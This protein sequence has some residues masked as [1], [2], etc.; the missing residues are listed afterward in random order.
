[1]DLG[2][3]ATNAV[4]G[5]GDLRG[6]IIVEAAIMVSAARYSSANRRKP[7]G[8]IERTASAM[9]AASRASVRASPACNRPY[10][11]RPVR[12]NRRRVCLQ[13]G[14]RPPEAR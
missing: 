4:S 12:E 9:I 2:E 14:L 5:L 3:L 7:N 6:K 11:A 13:H 10:G 1:M 8:G